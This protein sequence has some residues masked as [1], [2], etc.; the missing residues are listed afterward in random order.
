[1]TTDARINRLSD[2]Q[3]HILQHS[4]GVDHFG[5]GPRYRNHF[6][7]DSRSDDFKTCHGLVALGLMTVRVPSEI[8]GGSHIFHVT[9]V[10]IKAMAA[11]SHV[12]PRLTMDQR[13]YRAFLDADSGMSF[14]EWIKSKRIAAAATIV[15]QERVEGIA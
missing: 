12:A 15:R 2:E 3:L 9:D 8:S 1:M 7:A 11:Q 5:R 13:R 4:L 14:G 6:C 10:G